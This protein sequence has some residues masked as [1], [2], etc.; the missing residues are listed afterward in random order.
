MHCS[1]AR[2][3]AVN[4]IDENILVINSRVFTCICLGFPE[5]E[6]IY[7]Y[8]HN[9]YIFILHRVKHTYI[10]YIF[11]YF[12]KLHQDMFTDFEEKENGRER[13]KKRGGGGGEGERE[14][15]EREILM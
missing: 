8:A 9:M 6:N 4:S 11:I 2:D 12:L 3:T 10:R 15:K 5:K 14:R 1:G 7:I 13:E